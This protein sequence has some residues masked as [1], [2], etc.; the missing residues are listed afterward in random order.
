MQTISEGRTDVA[1]ALG[2][3][4][5]GLEDAGAN[6]LVMVCNTAHVF[7]D[8]VYARTS[9]PF[10]SIIEETVRAID[11]LC[12]AAKKVGVMATA[13]CLD[14]AI[15]QDAVTASGREA[16]VPEGDDMDELMDLIKA[17][18]SGDKG[19]GVQRGM[20]ASADKLVLAYT[21]SRNT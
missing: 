8:A 2:D 20:Q 12:P 21:A 18:K 1:D 19:E 13:G 10:I 15:Y 9:I 6:F 16:L 11:H 17:I 5:R 7:L 4:A 14:T 3:M